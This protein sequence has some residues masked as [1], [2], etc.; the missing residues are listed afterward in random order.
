MEKELQLIDFGKNKIIYGPQGCGKTS[1]ARKLT[2]GKE[3]VWLNP[4]NV[5]A[6]NKDIDEYKVRLHS[7]TPFGLTRTNPEVFVVDEIH[8]INLIHCIS[9]MN[10]KSEEIILIVQID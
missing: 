1:L 2:E 4:C 9:V 5:E 6:I 7:E 10:N 8:S 3:T